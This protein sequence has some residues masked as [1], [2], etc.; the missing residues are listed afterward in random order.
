VEKTAFRLPRCYPFWPTDF[1]SKFCE[2]QLQFSLRGKRVRGR[3]FV[4]PNPLS[5]TLN[6]HHKFMSRSFHKSVEKRAQRTKSA[7]IFEGVFPVFSGTAIQRNSENRLHFADL[8]QVASRTESF[9]GN[10]LK[11][12]KIAVFRPSST[13]WSPSLNF[14]LES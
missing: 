8:T 6:A 11:V 7:L 2:I 9:R 1:P 3:Y 13:T 4:C 14:R 12:H 5:E 10:G